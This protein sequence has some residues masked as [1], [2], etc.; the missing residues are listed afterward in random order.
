MRLTTAINLHIK[1]IPIFTK[2]TTP[3]LLINYKNAKVCPFVK[4]PGHLYL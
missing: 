2:E 1:S 4:L 3:W